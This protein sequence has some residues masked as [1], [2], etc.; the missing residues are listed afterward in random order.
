MSSSEERIA[1][2]LALLENLPV[3]DRQRLILAHELRLLQ[4][5]KLDGKRD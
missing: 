1:E 4:E 3:D 5:G 2:I